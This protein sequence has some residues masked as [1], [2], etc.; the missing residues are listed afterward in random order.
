MD[1]KKY[2]RIGRVLL[3]GDGELFDDEIYN[4]IEDAEFWLKESKHIDSAMYIAD[5]YV[6]VSDG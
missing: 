4:T 3:R 1:E 6:E 2:K 5:I